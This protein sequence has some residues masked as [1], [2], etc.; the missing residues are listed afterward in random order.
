MNK[1]ETGTNSIFKGY[2]RIRMYLFNRLMRLTNTAKHYPLAP[3]RD[4][5]QMKSK[6]VIQRQRHGGTS[7]GFIKNK[8]LPP[9]KCLIAIVVIRLIG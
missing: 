1:N 3:S 6:P 2:F 7:A 5:Q 9:G 8:V 4:Y